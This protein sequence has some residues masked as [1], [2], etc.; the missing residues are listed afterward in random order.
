MSF[1]TLKLLLESSQNSPLELRDVI[2]F[3]P[4]TY[5]KV[6][7][8]FWGSPRLTYHGLPFFDEDGMGPAYD[9]IEGAVKDAMSDE[10]F[11]V[12]I[13]IEMPDNDMGM[14]SF[15]YQGKIDDKQEVYLGYGQKE[16]A[17]FV[18][19]DAW[20]HEED[21]NTEWDKEFEKQTGHEF[22]SENDEHQEVFDHA[23]KAYSNNTMMGMLFRVDMENGHPEANVDFEIQG[24]FYRQVYPMVKRMDLIDLHLD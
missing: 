18:G 23:W 16:D 24:G 11:T 14:E 2:K 8:Q 15:S 19:Y 1:P 5:K 9:M 13:H 3:F 21:F 22:D 7:R 6:F 4:N 12:E 10:D 17:L 20:L